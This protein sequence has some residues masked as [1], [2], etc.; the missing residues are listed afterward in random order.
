MVWGSI[1]GH[2][3]RKRH[4]YCCMQRRLRGFRVA[5]AV[6]QHNNATMWFSGQIYACF[7]KT[8]PTHILYILQPYGSVIWLQTCQPIKSLRKSIWL[9]GLKLLVS[10]V[11]LTQRNDAAQV[12]WNMLACTNLN[13]CLI[14]FCEYCILVSFT[15]FQLKMSPW[16][17]QNFDKQ[18]LL[19][20]YQENNWTFQMLIW[21]SVSSV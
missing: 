9:P 6:M 12:F 10:S 8:M 11:L 16:A 17:F 21:D 3:V 1:S 5:Y 19:Y 4:R 18:L 2:D 13:C 15:A 14:C 7:S 20:I